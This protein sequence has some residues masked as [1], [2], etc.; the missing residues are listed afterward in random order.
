MVSQRYPLRRKA[1]KESGLALARVTQ[2]QKAAT[3]PALVGWKDVDPLLR[4]KHAIRKLVDLLRREHGWWNRYD[5]DDFGKHADA[6]QWELDRNL[7]HLRSSFPRPGTGS[8]HGECE[9]PADADV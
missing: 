6:A 8:P 7:R 2:I 9:D 1:A 4:E 3:D 5:P